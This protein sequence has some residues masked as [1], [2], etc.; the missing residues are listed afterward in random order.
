MSCCWK[1][2]RDIG[3]GGRCLD[4]LR[5]HL[6][7]RVQYVAGGD[8]RSASRRLVCG[9]PQGSVLGSLLITIYTSSLLKLLRPLVLQFHLFADDTQLY[10]E[11]VLSGMRPFT[12]SVLWQAESCVYEHK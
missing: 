8:A 5:G 1:L 4:W 11:F 9:V 2:E 7:D 3:L 12:L 6:S 10:L